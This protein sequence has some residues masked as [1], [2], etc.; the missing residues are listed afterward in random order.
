MKTFFSHPKQIPNKQ[1]G[2]RAECSLFSFQMYH[3]YA[4]YLLCI[5]HAFSAYK[6]LLVCNYILSDVNVFY[7]WSKINLDMMHWIMI[8]SCKFCLLIFYI[9]ISLFIILLSY[10][11]LYI[12]F[13]YQLY[14]YHKMSLRIENSSLFITITYIQVICILR[15]VRIYP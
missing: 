4:W 5:W 11:I 8:S 2:W 1:H 10:I 7:S 3:H 13:Y 12:L 9:L 6:E 15:V 14:K